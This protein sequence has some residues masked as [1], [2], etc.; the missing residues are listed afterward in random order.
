MT[1]RG[2]LSQQERTVIDD[3]RAKRYEGVHVTLGFALS[4]IIDRTLDNTTPERIATIV[5]EQ[6]LNSIE[7]RTETSFRINQ[8]TV[9]RIK[10][11]ATKAGVSMI[12]A[13]R[14]CLFSIQND[15]FKDGG[16]LD[17]PHMSDT[18][19]SAEGK[20]EG[21]IKKAECVE[22]KQTESENA[23]P[24][25]LYGILEFWASG[26]RD[27]YEHSEEAR[28]FF[29]HPPK[30][31]DLAISFFQ[32]LLAFFALKSEI[33]RPLVRL[34]ADG[35]DYEL[36]TAP[37][38]GI[39]KYI[40]NIRKDYFAAEYVNFSKGVTKNLGNR[41]AQKQ[42]I[43]ALAFDSVL[44]RHLSEMIYSPGNIMPVPDRFFNAYKGVL[45]K[46]SLSIMLDIIED[47]GYYLPFLNARIADYNVKACNRDRQLP[48]LTEE[49][50][51]QYRYF[52]INVR[53]SAALEEWFDVRADGHLMVHRLFRDESFERPLPKNEQ[54]EGY[55]VNI[56]KRAEARE[57]RLS[58]MSSRSDR[59]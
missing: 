13:V 32:P 16:Q 38:K 26:S 9:E 27:E 45:A 8:N 30:Y 3:Y 22:N 49:R 47:G 50:I 12:G 10:E 20:T 36:D 21:I 59:P 46:D 33:E 4:E 37:E 54:L 58:I 5:K 7:N 55:L 53:E 29:R 48:P 15:L 18:D 34:S 1:F 41:G 19:E 35:K 11:A 43:W 56:L 24:K 52:F 51:N 42:R 44:L 31:V 57:L 17:A 39:A 23:Y 6:S 14:A 28:K 2:C 40:R 25:D